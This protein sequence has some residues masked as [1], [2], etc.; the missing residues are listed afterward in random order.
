MEHFT[1]G[2]LALI[3]GAIIG[4]LGMFY[5]VW[6][7]VHVY[8]ISWNGQNMLIEERRPSIQ[9]AGERSGTSQALHGASVPEPPPS[10]EGLPV[11]E[12]VMEDIQARVQLGIERYGTVLRTG[13]GRDALWDLYQEQIDALMYTR[14]R[15][16]EE[17]ED[18]EW[19]PVS[20]PPRPNVVVNAWLPYFDSAD[21]VQAVCQQ[22]GKWF[23][24]YVN[25]KLPGGRIEPTHWR[26]SMGKPK[27]VLRERA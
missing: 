25:S 19:I 13:N 16:L 8:D 6:R 7:M 9:G 27:G 24:F 26:P 2:G 5:L 11:W 17:G 10:G 23:L 4:A 15:I 12:Y 18:D 22:D 3:L 21:V 1:V 14:Q 20:Q